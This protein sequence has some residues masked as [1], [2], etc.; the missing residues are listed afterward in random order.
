MS[1]KGKNL[2]NTQFMNGQ[3]NEVANALAEIL[4]PSKMGTA[5]DVTSE[6]YEI[7]EAV[8]GFMIFIP[9]NFTGGNIVATP[10]GNTEPI[11]YA[12]AAYK[13]GTYLR[14]ARFKTITTDTATKTG[15]EAWY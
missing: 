10:F 8:F 3:A 11:T 1:N 9:D 6:N 14:D 5:V 15:L 12:E 2:S 7:A 13:K 4:Q